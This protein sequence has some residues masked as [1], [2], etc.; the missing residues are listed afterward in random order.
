MIVNGTYFRYRKKYTPFQIDVAR[1][2]YNTWKPE[3][4]YDLGC[5]IGGYLDGFSQC[6]C[7]IAG[8]DLMYRIARRSMCYRVR[9]RTNAFDASTPIET[10]D[11]YDLVMSIEVAEH[12]DAKYAEIFCNNLVKL[13]KNRILLSAARPG[14][15]GNGHIN[16]KPKQ[17]WIDIITNLN[18]KYNIDEE[19]KI[20]YEIGS[21]DK[22]GIKNNI[23]VFNI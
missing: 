18:V 15:R 14:Q 12:L 8:S 19:K 5:G 13:A 6:G 3:S 17:Y 20:C 10:N 11:K 4:V 2:I 16:C 22:L 9:R 7:K 1:A 21:F 23:M